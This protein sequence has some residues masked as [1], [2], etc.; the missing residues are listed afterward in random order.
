[1]PAHAR[2]IVSKVVAAEY[3]ALSSYRDGIRQPVCPL[4]VVGV[5]VGEGVLA[6]EHISERRKR[7]PILFWTYVGEGV[8]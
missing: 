8:G 4:I 5:G 1:M 7:Q 6:G 3:K 2:E